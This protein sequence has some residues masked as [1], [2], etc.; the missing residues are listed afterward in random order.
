[1][2]GEGSDG[3]CDD[4]LLEQHRMGERCAAAFDDV[5]RE[6]AVGGSEQKAQQRG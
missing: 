3:L 5:H 4:A 6:A 1:M 2:D